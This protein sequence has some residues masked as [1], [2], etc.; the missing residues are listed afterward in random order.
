MPD[1]ACGR[2]GP[3]VTG[4]ETRTFVAG[5]VEM[6]VANQTQHADHN[7][8]QRND[9]IQQTRNDEN[10][11]S[12]KQRDQ[13]GE[14]K[15]K[16]HGVF[17]CSIDDRPSMRVPPRRSVPHRTYGENVLAGLR[18]THLRRYTRPESPFMAL[19]RPTE[20]QPGWQ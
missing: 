9:V 18:R 7:Q 11:Y 6:Y 19:M 4:R 12:G 8:V 1:A 15:M 2:L 14:A 17:P 13:R 20:R 16:I 3:A 5:L 10:E